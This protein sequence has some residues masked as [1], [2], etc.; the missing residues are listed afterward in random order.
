MSELNSSLHSL[1]KI[2]VNDDGSRK[3]KISLWDR[4][5]FHYY[6]FIYKM[7]Y[8]KFAMSIAESTIQVCNNPRHFI[9]LLTEL[10]TIIASMSNVIVEDIN[11]YL[12]KKF[13]SF[14]MD[15][16]PLTLNFTIEKDKNAERVTKYKV[17]AKYKPLTLESGEFMNDGNIVKTI[18]DVDV[19]KMIC[20]VESIYYNT[21]NIDQAN[22]LAVIKRKTYAIAPDGSVDNYYFIYDKDLKKREI[23]NYSKVAIFTLSPFITFLMMICKM[24]FRLVNIKPKMA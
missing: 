23:K 21:D 13:K 3:K 18:I 16:C 5:K 17:I 22:D 15:Q 10:V 7:K 11:T 12:S 20:N 8:K 19:V 6:N 1:T 4:I 14:G 24:E 9:F 2:C